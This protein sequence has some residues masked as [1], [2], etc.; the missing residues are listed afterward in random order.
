VSFLFFTR[1]TT[2]G[3]VTLADSD[4]FERVERGQYTAGHP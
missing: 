2:N 3:A 4:Q 1:Y